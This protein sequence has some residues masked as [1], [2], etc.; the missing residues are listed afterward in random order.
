MENY[1]SFAGL[2]QRDGF[3]WT[4]HKV[5]TADHYILTLFRLTGKINS[6]PFNPDKPPVMIAHGL[7]A[8]ASKWIGGL[9]F[10]G[11]YPF[12]YQ[13]AEAGFDVWLF[14]TRGTWYSM[15]HEELDAKEDSEYWEF[16]MS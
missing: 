12:H 2:M 7:S 14:N 3:T 10:N 8:D 13:L 16:D 11:L 9:D 4:D 15:E 1:E 6:G 5:T